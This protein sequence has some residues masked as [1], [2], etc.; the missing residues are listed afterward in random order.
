MHTIVQ[1]CATTSG[2]RDATTQKIRDGLS[3]AGAW[4]TDVH[5]FSGVQ[6][7]FVLELSPDRVRYLE[8]VLRA[9]GLRL[10]DAS[11]EALEN[12]VQT[13][14]DVHATL[15]VVFAHGDPD[16]RHDVPAIPG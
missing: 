6:T 10:D 13:T 11:L 15:A 1:L 12:A 16:L 9:A 4:L 2:D 14:G 3:E 8:S 5:F 7:V